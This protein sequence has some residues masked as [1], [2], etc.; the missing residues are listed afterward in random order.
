MCLSRAYLLWHTVAVVP[1]CHDVGR[2]T[3]PH[4]R[5][6]QRRMLHSWIEGTWIGDIVG[7]TGIGTATCP[8][9]AG[10]TVAAAVAATTVGARTTAGHMDRRWQP[11]HGTLSL[12]ILVVTG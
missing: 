12:I 2:Y 5:R 10:R 8:R 11:T 9:D 6:V 1:L 7:I 4:S 3:D